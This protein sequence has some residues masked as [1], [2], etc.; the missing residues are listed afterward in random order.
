MDPEGELMGLEALIRLHMGEKE[1]A[2]DL[3]KT[4]LSANPH[5]REAWQWT[6][7]WW[8]RPLQEDPEFRALVA[9]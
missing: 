8:W 2:L 1:Q 7:H 9:G 3:L 6:A 5:H 4:Y